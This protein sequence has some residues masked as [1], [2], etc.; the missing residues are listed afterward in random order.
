MKIKLKK[1]LLKACKLK[2]ILIFII[3][4]IIIKNNDNNQY[5]EKKNN[6]NYMNNNKFVLY[7]TYED[8]EGILEL[9]GDK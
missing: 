9:E 2:I 3:I 8:K 4:Q 7:F 6:I 1:R 5:D